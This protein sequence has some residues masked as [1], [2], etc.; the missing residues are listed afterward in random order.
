M[1]RMQEM[2]AQ[3]GHSGK[4]RPDAMMDGTEENTD[5]NTEENN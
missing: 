3:S 4:M 5:E 1:E 2:R